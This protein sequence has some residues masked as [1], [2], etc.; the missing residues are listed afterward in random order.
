MLRDPSHKSGSR[1]K[2]G[3][4][5]RTA[6]PSSQ[7]GPGDRARRQLRVTPATARWRGQLYCEAGVRLGE[8]PVASAETAT[9]HGQESPPTR[10]ESNGLPPPASPRHGDVRRV[11][12]AATRTR[13]T[14]RPRAH[15]GSPTFAPYAKPRVGV[16]AACT[17][18]LASP[19]LQPQ[20]WIRIRRKRGRQLVGERLGTHGKVQI[21]KQ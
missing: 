21:N 7:G 12:P 5:V 11:P 8:A 1:T 13:G 14:A 20:R 6:L 9:C 3:L 4:S 19:L 2:P 16:G 17:E 18:Q 15:G 10:A